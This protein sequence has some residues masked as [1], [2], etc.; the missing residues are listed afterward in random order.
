MILGRD[1]CSASDVGVG[2][3]ESLNHHLEWI[4]LRAESGEI[5][6]TVL[7]VEINHMYFAVSGDAF[8]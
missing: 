2:E 1:Q 6:N 3:A 8:T 7:C 5:N 4:I